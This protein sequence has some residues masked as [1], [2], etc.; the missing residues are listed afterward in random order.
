MTK[1]LNTTTLTFLQETTFIF[2]TIAFGWITGPPV[3][4]CVFP[5]FASLQ[6]SH[7]WFHFFCRIHIA[8]CQSRSVLTVSVPISTLIY[9]MFPQL[10]S[11]KVPTIRLVTHMFVYGRGLHV[12]S[13]P[14]CWHNLLSPYRFRQLIPCPRLFPRDPPLVASYTICH[15]HSPHS[16]DV[17]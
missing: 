2:Y 8:F 9:Q 4:P 6:T 17:H 15:A 3:S 14:I 12:H 1:I 5:E 13:T 10:D 16:G 7:L 11:P